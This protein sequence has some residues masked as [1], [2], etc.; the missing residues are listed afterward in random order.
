M[1]FASRQIITIENPDDE[2]FAAAMAAILA[3]TR[4]LTVES[5]DG[6]PAL[7]SSRVALMAAMRFHSNGR[8]LIFDGL[9]GPAPAAVLRAG[10]IK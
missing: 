6:L 2:S 5:V 8:A 4:R 3:F 9:P 1:G 10:A 7:E